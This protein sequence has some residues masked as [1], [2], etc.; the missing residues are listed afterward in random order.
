MPKMYRITYTYLDRPSEKY[1]ILFG[2]N[3]SDQAIEMFIV[4]KPD[5]DIKLVEDLG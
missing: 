4:A 1:Q 2:A 3:S 5:A